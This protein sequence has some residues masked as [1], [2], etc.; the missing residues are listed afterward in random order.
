MR[1]SVVIPA[2]N[3]EW[4]LDGAIRSVIDQD[5]PAHEVIV[6]DD[7]ST[8]GT[9]GIADAHADVV[10]IHRPNGGLASARNAGAARAT[11]DAVFFLDADDE[12]LPGA[13]RSVAEAA[14]RLGEWSAIVPNCIRSHDGDVLAWPRSGAVRV[15]GRR[16]VPGLIR[17][18]WLSPHALIRLDAWRAYPYREELRA[19]EDLD[20]WLRM[21]L[22]GR[23]IAVLGTPGVFVREGRPGSLS[24]RVALMRRSRRSAFAS[25]WGRTDLTAAERALVGYQLLRTSVGVLA[26]R[27]SVDP[28]PTPSCLQV[29]VED[30]AG[31]P[32]HVELLHEGLGDRVAWRSHGLDPAGVRRFGPAWIRGTAAVGRAI[33]DRSTVVHAH[34]LRAAAVAL[35][36]ALVRRAPLVVTM[37]G[38]HVVRGSAG[39]GALR[40]AR[41]I[42][43]RAARVLVLSPSDAAAIEAAGLAPREKVVQVRA[44]FRR[45]RRVRRDT[46]RRRLGVPDDATAVA[47]LGRLSEEKDPITFVRA[48]RRLSD[49][50]PVVALVGGDGPLRVAVEAAGGDAPLRMTGWVDD[51]GPLLSAADLFVSTSRWEGMPLAVLEAASVGLPL[52]LTDVPGNRDAAEHGIPAELV[53]PGDSVALATA[54]DVL[55]RDRR[56]RMGRRAAR[57][58]GR[59][60]GVALLADDVLDVY[61]H[62]IDE[63][64]GRRAEKG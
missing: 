49:R 22:D 58:V 60:F 57:V 56:R 44:G 21:L 29:F 16:D 37:H 50:R 42:L 17:R 62:V 12:L 26:A 64:L 25:L 36:A 38:V 5:H 53:P 47:W 31:G 45:P 6:V 1:I 8:D 27:P 19:V 35:P 55:D 34:G 32:T 11:G 48:I 63:R 40:L 41:A 15:L 43:R 9:A 39:R 14:A 51:P 13:L 54:I 4:W 2:Y 10:A 24:G 7:G 59:E 52:V 46:A 20:V 30:G 23:T 28:T 18:N 33:R 61:R 3:V